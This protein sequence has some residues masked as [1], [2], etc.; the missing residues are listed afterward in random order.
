[1]TGDY[2]GWALLE[3]MGHRRLFCRVTEV[4]LFGAKFCRADVPS[5]RE[6]GD[7]GVA[8]SQFY[9][10]AAI[11]SL[12]PLPESECRSRACPDVAEFRVLEAPRGFDD[13]EEC[14]EPPF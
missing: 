12:S 3:V 14:D 10:A 13:G 11:F 5:S 6:E 7:P 1:M 8:F 4:E 9:P 2:E